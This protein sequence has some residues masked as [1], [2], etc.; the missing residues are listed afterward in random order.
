MHPLRV[1][2]K[3]P[4]GPFL[5]W[6]GGKTQ[7]L[8]QLQPYLHAGMKQGQ[9]KEYCEPFLGGGA[10]FF[11]LA[12]KYKLKSATL[13]DI[14]RELVLV[15]RV[16]QD[17]VD[18]LIYALQAIAG[19][20]SKLNEEKRKAFFY[21]VRKDYNRTPLRGDSFKR[22]ES[23]RIARAAE[24]LFLNRTCYNGLFRLNSKGLFN[25][26]FGKYANPRICNIKN[27][28]AASR[29]LQVAEI[30]VCDFGKIK[31]ASVRDS[32][33]YLDPPYRPLSKTSS[34]NSYHHTPFN[35]TEQIRLAKMVKKFARAGARVLLSNSD[36]RNTN[37][38][39]DFFEKLYKD[40]QINRVRAGRLINSNG[41]ARALI[42]ELVITNYR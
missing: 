23:K 12:Q 3:L 42:N 28:Q 16:V 29:C 19:K 2:K 17:K 14:N 11:H 32:F 4:A 33:V 26:P 10:V 6:A 27:L 7:L 30:R 5:K 20:Y 13:Y 1:P 36:P 15:Y 22:L 41:Q 25:V 39:D 21:R 9:V 8:K 31:P 18:E 34:F 38:K 40:F 24:M 35:D 37:P